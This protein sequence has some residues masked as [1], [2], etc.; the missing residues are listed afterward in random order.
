M[1]L[2]DIIVL[3]VVQGLAE[4][5]PISS[6]GHLVLFEKLLK[7]A[8]TSLSF[9]IFLHLASLAVLLF[10]FRSQIWSIAQDIFSAK[11]PENNRRHWFWYMV[12]STAVTALIGWL[13][14]DEVT[15]LR[16]IFWVGI[17]LILSGIF[18]LATKWSKSKDTQM[19]YWIAIIL[20]L[21]Q[22]LAVLPGLS[23]S[24]LV[25]STALL[26]GLNKKDAF[27]YGFI[28]VIPAILGAF[29]L[30]VKD[31]QFEPIML[32]GLLVT[33]LVSY[34]TLRWLRNLMDKNYFYRFSYY[35]LLLGLIILFL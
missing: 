21:V 29:A 4:W 12:L 8:G 34:F 17:F 23:R 32:L 2:V 19:N 9:D 1:S 18:V 5:L 7:M 31:L 20:G 11:N 16:E 28:L 15:K 25:I 13:L 14:Y 6:D 22:G 3:S 24:A 10:F 33:V 27:E 26:L 35:T 30:S